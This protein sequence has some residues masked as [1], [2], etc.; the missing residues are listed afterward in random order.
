MLLSDLQPSIVHRIF[1]RGK[2]SAPKLTSAEKVRQWRA[3]NPEKREAERKRRRQWWA[4]VGGQRRK[5]W[6][7]ANPEQCEAERKRRR[8]R[9]RRFV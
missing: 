1:K 5:E 7:A 6:R 2:S 8:E 3:A 9:R 4:E